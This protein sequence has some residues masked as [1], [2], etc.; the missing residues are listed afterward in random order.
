[1]ALTKGRVI[2][3]NLKQKEARWMRPF[4]PL[5]NNSKQRYCCKNVTLFMI[6][7]PYAFLQQMCYREQYNLLSHTATTTCSHQEHK[8]L[9]CYVARVPPIKQLRFYANFDTRFSNIFSIVLTCSSAILS[10][11]IS[12]NN[13]SIFDFSFERQI[14]DLCNRLVSHSA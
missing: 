12:W 2:S 1:M 14:A 3:S 4:S 8:L 11:L 9:L 5:R 6:E 13:I 10:S 7:V